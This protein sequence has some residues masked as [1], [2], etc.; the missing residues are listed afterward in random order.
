MVLGEPSIGRATL[1][2]TATGVLMG[3]ATVLLA[4]SLVPAAPLP[5]F[6]A[7]LTLL[8]TWA[9]LASLGWAVLVSAAVLL[10]ALTGQRL[11]VRICCPAAWRRPVLVLC[12]AALVSGVAGPSVAAGGSGT[13]PVDGPRTAG[14]PRLDR[15]AGG[16]AP[17][18]PSR[19]QD[20][21]VRVRPGDS[22]WR[23]VARRNPH[24]T[25]D[26]VDAQVRRLY[27]A[28][29]GAIGPD[30]DLIQPGTLL[31]PIQ[32]IQPIHPTDDDRTEP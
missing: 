24:A 22:L 29:R 30:P 28:N 3:A 14:L 25:A 20:A 1:A 15:P 21:Q 9:L 16:P 12:G 11:L 19:G 32:P 10:Q 6:G 4:H 31:Q 27:Q 18:A 13:S 23:I 2:V 8:A 17:A 5:D 26:V 7:A